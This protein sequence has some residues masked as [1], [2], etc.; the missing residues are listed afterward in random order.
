MGPFVYTFGTRTDEYQ[1]CLCVFGST[2]LEKSTT[3]QILPRA[4]RRE[5]D[6]QG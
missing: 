1:T 4:R 6:W 5:N 2:R 3:S